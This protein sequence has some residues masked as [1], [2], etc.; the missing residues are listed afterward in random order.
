MS[1]NLTDA[2]S[3]LWLAGPLEQ[4]FPYFAMNLSVVLYAT[5]LYTSVL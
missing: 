3:T 1:W 4:V 5:S 2:V